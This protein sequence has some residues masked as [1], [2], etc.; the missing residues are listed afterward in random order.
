MIEVDRGALVHRDLH[1]DTH[2]VLGR[3]QMID[4]VETLFAPRPVN[5]GHV[6]DIPEQA[7]RIVAQKAHHRNDVARL[8]L[9]RQFMMRNRMPLT[10]AV[11]ASAIVTA[12]SIEDFIH[13]QRSIVAVR[14]IFFCRRSTP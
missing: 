13:R 12:E 10:E 14:R 1:A 11:S 3:K 8:R 6:D 7:A 4:H 5:R 2:V 9:D